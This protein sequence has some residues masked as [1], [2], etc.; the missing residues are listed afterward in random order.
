MKFM[1][2]LADIQCR[3]DLFESLV[4]FRAIVGIEEFP[5]RKD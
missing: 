5:R 3:L 4:T 1:V 2:T